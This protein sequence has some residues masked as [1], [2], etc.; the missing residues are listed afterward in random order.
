MSLFT[1]F[2][3]VIIGSVALVTQILHTA[4][5]YQLYV[6]VCAC[7][8]MDGGMT[9][10]CVLWIVEFQAMGLCCISSTSSGGPIAILCFHLWLISTHLAVCQ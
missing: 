3:A 5:E 2:N 1:G 4:N 9:L 7:G 8:W 6:C 10:R